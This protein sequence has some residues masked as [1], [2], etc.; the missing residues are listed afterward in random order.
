[1]VYTSSYVA[2]CLKEL[3]NLVYKYYREELKSEPTLADIDS[4]ISQTARYYEY[5]GGLWKLICLPIAKGWMDYV[6]KNAQSTMSWIKSGGNFQDNKGNII[7]LPHL[8]ATI[9][10]YSSAA[11]ALPIAEKEWAGWMGDLAQVTCQVLSETDPK[12]H[13]DYDYLISHATKLIGNTTPGISSFGSNDIYCD[14]DGENIYNML[15]KMRLVEAFDTYYNI[16]SNYLSRFDIFIVNM[17]ED[18]AFY[19]M[20]KGPQPPIFE[21]IDYNGKKFMPTQVQRSA[22]NGTFANYVFTHRFKVS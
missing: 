21:F 8:F 20:V 12:Y 15:S 17:G 4:L 9:E 10:G 11:F 19:K 7:G 18:T 22:V 1:M 2:V 3:K 13:G 6:L 16:R 5:T 14:V